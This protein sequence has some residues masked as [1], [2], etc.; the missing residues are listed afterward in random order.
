MPN[1]AGREEDMAKGLSQRPEDGRW[2]MGL[3]RFGP[4]VNSTV[5]AFLCAILG[6][7]LWAFFSSAREDRHFFQEELQNF[8]KEFLYHKDVEE[9]RLEE[10][11]KVNNSLLVDI[12]AELRAKGIMK[13]APK[14]DHHE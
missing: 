14:V 8:R 12:R 11:M 4:W 9:R 10:L 6:F 13:V 7:G 5:T 3:G 1:R 2:S